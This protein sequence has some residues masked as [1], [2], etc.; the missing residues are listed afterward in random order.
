MLIKRVFGIITFLLL[1]AGLWAA[2]G[3]FGPTLDEKRGKYFYVPSTLDQP[4]LLAKI[5][6][7]QWVRSSLWIELLL[8]TWK[9]NK[10]KPGRYKIA[11]GTSAFQFIR[12]LKNSKQAY[13]KLVINKIRTKEELAGLIGE[14][15]DSNIDST[16]LLAFFNNNDSLQQFGVDTC[17]L[18]AKVLPYTYEISWAEHPAQLLQ[19]FASSWQQFWTEDQREKAKA[20][21]LNPYQVSTL[22]SIVEEETNYQPDRYKIASTYLNRLRIGMKLQADPTAKY[23]TRNFKLNRILYGHL[24]T[25]SP[26]NTYV[27]TGLPPGPIC[28]PSLD[29]IKAVLEAPSTNYLF[30]VAS[31]KFD[32]T[33]IF[34]SSYAEHQQY[35]KLFH[36]EQLKR[37]Q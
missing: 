17:T 20:I 16:E 3:L 19:R 35:V 22:A 29:A 7:E 34:T 31:W 37:N 1:L 8:K 26:Y 2:W 14:R 13:V 32:G 27:H 18:L 30:F 25:A 24:T 10:V 5:K 4:A 21:G 36:A 23:V 33:S 9:V 28:T 11:N 15:I 6:E 12:T